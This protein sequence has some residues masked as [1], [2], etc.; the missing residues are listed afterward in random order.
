MITRLDAPAGIVALKAEGDIT[1]EDYETVVIPAVDAATAGDT[2][3]RLVYVLSPGTD[4]KASAAL[5]DA[6]VG[7][8]H[9]TDFK[10]I[11]LVTDRDL[12][13]GVVV[14]MGWLMPGK[15]KGF[16]HDEY[17]AAVAWAGADD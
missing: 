8:E 9:F 1:K 11:A 10:R 4:Y 15:V 3:A 16:E 14:A 7:I 2:K 12:L 5:A 17:D 6:K 13:R